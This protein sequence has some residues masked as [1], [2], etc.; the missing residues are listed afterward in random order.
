MEARIAQIGPGVYSEAL[1]VEMRQREGEDN[2][3]G[4]DEAEYLR[5]AGGGKCEGGAVQSIAA[6]QTAVHVTAAAAHRYGSVETE[7]S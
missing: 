1:R 5:N 4:G 7:G 3:E 2:G 6:A